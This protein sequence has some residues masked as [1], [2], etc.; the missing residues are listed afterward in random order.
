MRMR[1]YWNCAIDTAHAEV[2]VFVQVFEDAAILLDQ[3]AAAEVDT[4]YVFE[5]ALGLIGSTPEVW[6]Q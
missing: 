2:M 3:V 4:C 5:L 1:V 6:Y